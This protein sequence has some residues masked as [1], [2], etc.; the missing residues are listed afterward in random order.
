MYNELYQS[1]ADPDGFDQ[2]I[3]RVDRR[4][5]ALFVDEPDPDLRSLVD[6]VD[7]IR[8]ERNQ[9]WGEASE[10]EDELERLRE[11][12]RDIAEQMLRRGVYAASTDRYAADLMDYGRQLIEQCDMTLENDQ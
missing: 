7:R 2:L 6:N 11:M 3:D 9:A 12:V 8:E 4:Y 5:T 1:Q 10:A